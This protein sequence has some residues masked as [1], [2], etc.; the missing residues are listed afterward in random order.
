MRDE[1]MGGGERITE[2]GRGEGIGRRRG[3][4]TRGEE[5]GRK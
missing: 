1:D 3:G 2:D 4:A 5:V